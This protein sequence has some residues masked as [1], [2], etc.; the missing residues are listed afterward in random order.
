MLDWI[1]DATRS[2]NWTLAIILT[3][4]L[5]LILVVRIFLD[6]DKSALWRGRVYRAVYKVTGREEDEKKY[7][8]NDLRGRL[9]LARRK[10]QCGQVI[11]PQAVR[12]D[13][14]EGVG[15]SA[16]TVA[17]GEYVVRLN[18]ANQQERNIVDL[19]RIIAQRTT[20]VGARHL[21]EKR[22]R[23]SIDLNVV[24]HLIRA[25]GD[26]EV[27]QWFFEHEYNP[28]IREDEKLAEWNS[29]VVEV[30]ERG[31]FTR[32]LLVELD[33]FVRRISGLEPRPYMTGEIEGWIR[34]LYNIARKPTGERTLL[35]YLK[36][37][38]RTAIILVAKT[39]KI[40]S[41]GVD[42]YV[43]AVHYSL[44][45]EC[46]SVYL[47]IF[48]KSFLREHDTGAHQAFVQ[49]VRDMNRTILKETA[50]DQDFVLD[51]MCRDNQGRRRKARIVR[52]VVPVG[53]SEVAA[54]PLA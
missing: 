27:E 46:D 48:D 11:L 49:A 23:R 52:Y 25:V 43:K 19:A 45:E 7:I 18:P 29:R 2:A 15:S 50:L 37:H 24:K 17:E 8:G 5:A 3:L 14:V 28:A 21:I 31:F 34:F 33:D 41:E 40:L 30:D 32:I 6:E 51:Y 47:V 44:R 20:L 4:V 16:Q 26:K 9:N 12:V 53:K 42:P 22:L 1:V 35:S 13:W 36:A 38:I 54:T 10:L 39:D